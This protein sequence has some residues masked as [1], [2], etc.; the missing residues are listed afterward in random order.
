MAVK[1]WSETPAANAAV[2]AI[3]WAEGQVPSSVNNS[4]RQ[5][6]AELAGR[7]KTHAVSAKEFGVRADGT[8]DDGPALSA[9]INGAEG[10]TVL[11]PT[12]T[13]RVASPLVIT[14]KAAH[15]RGAWSARGMNIGA[16]DGRVG[17][18]IDASALG[19]G[20]WLWSTFSTAAP[21][22][23]TLGPFVIENVSIKLGAAHGLE[24]GRADL[25]SGSLSRAEY[26][27]VSDGAGQRYVHGVQ[28]RNVQISGA[29]ASAASSA[30]G[31][32]ARSGQRLIMLTK[33]FESTIE[34]VS[35][36]GGDIAIESW[37][38]D[39]LSIDN[40][41]LNHCHVPLLLQRSN[42]FGAAQHRVSRFQSE[43]YTFGCIILDSV[44]ASL[45]DIRC[46]A[47]VGSP[48]RHGVWDM[49]A[50]LGITADV[51]AGSA[52]LAFKQAGVAKDMTG[53]LHPYLSL[54]ELDVAGN[55]EL[56]WVQ[57]VAGSAVTVWSTNF[58]FVESAAGCTVR[59]IHGYSLLGG[60]T[61][62][63]TVNGLDAEPYL[64]TPALVYVAQTGSMH[65]HGAN[66][67]PGSNTPTNTDE[68][69]ARIVGNT[70]S[71]SPNLQ[72]GLVMHGSTATL[73]GDPAH[74][75]LV[76]A[77]NPG[78]HG[79]HPQHPSYRP[80]REPAP[81][82]LASLPGFREFAFTPRNYTT[83]L[84]GLDQRVF[85]V[86]PGDAN[87]KQ[88]LAWW[89]LPAGSINRFQLESMLSKAHRGWVSIAIIARAKTGSTSYRWQ[90][91]GAGGSQLQTRSIGSEWDVLTVPFQ[92]VP[93][94]WGG[95]RD[96]AYTAGLRILPDGDIQLSGIHVREHPSVRL[97]GRARAE[98]SGLKIGPKN[99]AVPF[100][101]LGIV[102]AP[103]NAGVRVRIVAMPRGANQGYAFCSATYELHFSM[104]GGVVQQVG[105]VHELSKHADS[106]NAGSLA[107][108]FS[109]AATVSGSAMLLSGTTTVAGTSAA[110]VA[111]AL[112]Y[113]AVESL[114]ERVSEL[115]GL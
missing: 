38:C 34:N 68:C 83:N 39:A 109:L 104:Y 114:G 50:E 86:G 48:A 78:S 15:V 99:S 74:P 62:N 54:I 29:D 108:D 72:R 51:T 77:D 92:N 6:M 96:V 76:A 106:I 56:C 40:V 58:K 5:M 49:T 42:F 3:N 111:E 19:A 26:D 103:G 55:T 80:P 13:I 73:V 10:R 36:R 97:L 23:D 43:H 17:T 94:E 110:Q 107:L 24:F 7:L 100:A 90:T 8:T 93:V 21:L 41:R 67:N 88:R 4:A 45:S 79:W 75:L 11:L 81:V 113:Y 70:I 52:T 91:H 102:H 82:T 16:G 105:A 115:E 71:N 9:A 95:A 65:V 66:K 98:L 22:T 57:A 89:E 59:R 18:L 47:N 31:V 35:T 61:F 28:L 14:A 1:D 44:S 46:E 32:L 64:R 20:Q 87:T 27:P 84:D 2:G 25:G 37:G 112:I 85:R 53:I 69:R 63:I 30:S 101:S 12:G 60:G 33:C